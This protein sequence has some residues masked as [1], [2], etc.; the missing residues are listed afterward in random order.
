MATFDRVRAGLVALGVAAGLLAPSLA[1]AAVVVGFGWGG[2]WY[3]P[4]GSVNRLA[5]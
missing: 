2:G 1:Q 4:R 3:G 5:M